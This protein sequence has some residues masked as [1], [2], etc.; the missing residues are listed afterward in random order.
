M[1]WLSTRTRRWQEPVGIIDLGGGSVQ[2][3]FPTP[4]ASTAPAGYSQH[5]DFGGRKHE[6][7]LKS[8]L[9][10]GLD[11]ARNAAL[12]LLVS[13]HEVRAA[14]RAPPF[15]HARARPPERRGVCHGPM[16]SNSILH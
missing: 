15:C 11:A 5:L 1:T 8:H 7:Y 4:A 2:I 9:G 14:V 6:V 16:K 10:F 12:D 3:V 13:K